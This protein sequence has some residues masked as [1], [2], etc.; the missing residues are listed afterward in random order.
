MRW[1]LAP[2]R[3]HHHRATF[4]STVRAWLPLGLLVLALSATAA[5]V[6]RHAPVALLR[7]LERPYLRAGSARLDT[8]GRAYPRS[9][10]GADG[11]RVSL[12]RPPLRLVSQFWSLDE[13]L[14]TVVPPERVVGVSDSAYSRAFSNV[15]ELA[16]RHRPM[17]VSNGGPTDPERVLQTR[18]DLLFLASST[19]ADIAHVLRLAGVPSYAMHTDFSTLAEIEEHIR[20]VGYLAGEDERGQGAAA[21]FHDALVRAAARRPM[22]ARPRVLG[23]GGRYSYGSNTVFHDICR[24][25]G[26]VNVAG[27]SLR[28]YD[29]ISGEQIVRWNPEW[30]VVGAAAGEAEATRARLLADPAIAVTQAAARGQLVV[31]DQRV[32]LPLSP[33]TRRLVEA[34]ADALYGPTPA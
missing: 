14:Y 7:P 32:F 2:R 11:V 3:L 9:A 24:L 26:A 10:R 8:T 34:L 6:E 17:R 5:V 13:F 21:R 20:Q 1:G 31:L 27:A 4:T 33:F 16:E 28:G 15:L 12:A 19:R 23:L 25:L 29:A 18:P 30:I 22:G